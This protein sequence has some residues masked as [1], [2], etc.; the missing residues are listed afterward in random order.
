MTKFSDK[1]SSWWPIMY[2]KFGGDILRSFQVLAN[3]RKRVQNMSPSG[4]RVKRCFA[5]EL[6]ELCIPLAG[7]AGSAHCRGAGIWTSVPVPRLPV[8]TDGTRHQ[9]CQCWRRCHH[10]PALGCRRWTADLQSEVH[11]ADWALGRTLAWNA[12]RT[13]LP[14]RQ[15]PPRALQLHVLQ[16]NLRMF[17]LSGRRSTNWLKVE[18]L[19]TLAIW[20]YGHEAEEYIFLNLPFPSNPKEILQF[21]VFWAPRSKIC[22]Y[23]LSAALFGLSAAPQHISQHYT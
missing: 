18:C 12:S 11:S 3:I 9:W 20:S 23:V 2:G 13:D 14:A 6:P 7:A 16:C 19:L 17:Y 5:R 22:Y 15:S 10:S 8:R 1:A 21:A 4:A